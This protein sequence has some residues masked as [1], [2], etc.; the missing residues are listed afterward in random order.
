[1]GV[2]NCPRWLE[3]LLYKS[4]SF[5]SLRIVSV[6]RSREVA[7]S[8]RLEMWS[9]IP[10]AIAIGAFALAVRFSEVVPLLGGPLREVPL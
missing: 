7:A 9:T 3:V 5:G 2:A 6:V 1:M 8:R 4:W 10:M